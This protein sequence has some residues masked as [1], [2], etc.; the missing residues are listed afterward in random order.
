[1]LASPPAT[2]PD[3]SALTVHSWGSDGTGVRVRFSSALPIDVGTLSVTARSGGTPIL[4]GGGPLASL[5]RV[6]L[7]ASSPPDGAAT[8]VVVR[9]S[10]SGGATP[11]EAWFVR[12]SEGDAVDIEVV[13]RDALGRV[14]VR[15]A[16]VA[17]GA[18]DPPQIT[19]VSSWVAAPYLLAAW[20]TDTPPDDGTGPCVLTVTGASARFFP[21]LGPRLPGQFGAIRIP[22][23][24]PRVVVSASFPMPAIRDASVSPLQPVDVDVVRTTVDGATTYVAAVRVPAPGSMTLSIATPAGQAGSTRVDF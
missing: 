19:V 14:S 5:P 13:L 11:Y 16:T 12:S 7:P 20:T 15:S 3:L 4:T 23:P 8:G 22:F 24:P 9:G 10:P 17:P 2:P 6:D 21:P 1:M 18:I